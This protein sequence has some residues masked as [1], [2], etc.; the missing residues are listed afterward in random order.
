LKIRIYP[1]STMTKKLFAATA[2]LSLT[3]MAGKPR[4]ASVSVSC[5]QNADGTCAAGAQLDVVGSGFSKQVQLVITSDATG[6]FLDNAIYNTSKGNLSA[7]ETPTLTNGGPTE[8][9]TVN[10]YDLD[11][12]GNPSSTPTASTQFTIE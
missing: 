11:N 6:Y 1:V 5:T 7:F 2:L 4:P 3:L 12:K 10:V 9:Y 8:T